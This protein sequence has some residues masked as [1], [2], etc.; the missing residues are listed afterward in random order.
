LIGML[1]LFDDMWD[2]RLQPK[3]L[4]NFDEKIIAQDNKFSLEIKQFSLKIKQFSP[5]KRIYDHLVFVYNPLDV[6]WMHVKT[7]VMT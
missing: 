7:F 6:S 5:K 2:A 4:I 3:T 1:D